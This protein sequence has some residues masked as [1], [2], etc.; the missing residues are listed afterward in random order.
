MIRPHFFRGLRFVKY[1][2]EKALM[3][4]S[5]LKYMLKGYTYKAAARLP[6]FTSTRMRDKSNRQMHAFSHLPLFGQ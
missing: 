4:N 1:H 3:P 6:V 2:S 5:E